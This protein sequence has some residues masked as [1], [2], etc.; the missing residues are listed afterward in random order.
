MIRRLPIVALF[1]QGTPPSRERIAL[2]RDT[3][4]MIA[5]LGAHLLTGGGYGVMEAAC[6][7]FVG[8]E[9]RKG[10][11]IGIVPRRP[12]G[13]FDEP[14]RDLQGRPYPNAFVEIPIMTP[15][16]PRVGDWRSEPGRNHINVLT[17]D[18]ML[19]LPG[20]TGT[21]NELDMA[22]SYRGEDAM[23]AAARRTILLGPRGEFTFGHLEAFLHA[24]TVPAARELL[25]AILSRCGFRTR[26]TA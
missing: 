15:L 22:M 8:V 16:P 6:E 13:A 12:D 4:R 19:A 21:R 5:G 11:A 7:G 25:D 26:E 1:G 9:P 14:N 23:V 18:A 10:L 20:G 2:A 24:D 3:G 17:A